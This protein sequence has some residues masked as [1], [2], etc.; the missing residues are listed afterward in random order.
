MTTNALKPAPKGKKPLAPPPPP[1]RK[2]LNT[3][4]TINGVKVKIMTGSIKHTEGI[5]EGLL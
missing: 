4:L 1:P 2:G 3:V 5:R